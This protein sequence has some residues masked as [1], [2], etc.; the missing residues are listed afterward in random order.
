M[1]GIFCCQ[2]SFR[3]LSHHYIPKVHTVKGNLQIRNIF[4]TFYDN[5]R[6]ACALRGTNVTSVL[7]ALNMSSGNVSK[8]K[9]GVTPK[10]DKL[11]ALAE[12]LEVSA[13][14][15]LGTDN[16]VLSDEERELIRR[17]RELSNDSQVVVKSVIIQ[18][19]RIK[20]V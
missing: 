13:D 4:M 19:G 15:L 3:S 1:R 8:W 14:Y 2:S 12:H 10:A 6:K 7:K 5:L 20:N 16:I 11:N 9:S 18:E 17:Y